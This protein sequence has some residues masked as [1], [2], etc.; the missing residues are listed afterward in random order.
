[1]TW[2]QYLEYGIRLMEGTETDPVWRGKH[3][4]MHAGFKFEECFLQ[5]R[6]VQDLAV[7]AEACFRRAQCAHYQKDE[8][9][10]NRWMNMGNPLLEQA[11]L[12]DEARA[13]CYVLKA[14]IMTDRHWYRE[15]FHLVQSALELCSNNF[16]L[17]GDCEN[18][19]GRLC[20]E[21]GEDIGVDLVGFDYG[22]D[23]TIN[24]LGRAVQSF[25]FVSDDNLALQTQV[26]AMG[27][28]GIV[29]QRREGYYSR[30]AGMYFWRAERLFSKFPID[31]CIRARHWLQRARMAARSFRPQALW[32]WLKSLGP[33]L[34]YWRQLR[35]KIDA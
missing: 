10:I 13:Q 5:D 33:S 9:E 15:A 8:R 7:R 6:E 2:R 27:L 4:F 31:P 32:F 14:I 12:P 23:K 29:L 17:K 34:S 18:R 20:L 21:H 16:K 30:D 28:V 11:G 35:K 25:D 1:M 26:S 19:L 24:Y 22:L 3:D